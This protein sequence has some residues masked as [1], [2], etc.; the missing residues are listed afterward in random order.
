VIFSIKSRVSYPVES[1][2]KTYKFLVIFIICLLSLYCFFN[3]NRS[4]PR[5]LIL[6]P[7]ARPSKALQL[8]LREEL[9]NHTKDEKQISVEPVLN[10]TQ[11]IFYFGVTHD[12]TAGS[13]LDACLSTW[14]ARIQAHTGQK[15]I[16]YSNKADARVDHVVSTDDRDLYKDIT[17]RMLA[18]WRHV[19]ETYPDFEWYVRLWD[20]TIVFPETFEQ[21]IDGEA[22]NQL[23][24]IGRLAFEKT[25]E[26]IAPGRD[27]EITR[28]D[29]VFLDGGAGSLISQAALRVF[30]ENLDRCEVWMREELSQEIQC[31]FACEDVLLSAC[32]HRLLNITFK[33]GLGLYHTTPP[34]LP[35]GEH[36]LHRDVQGDPENTGYNSVTRSLHYASPEAMKRIDGI[37][38]ATKESQANQ[39]TCAFEG[40]QE[41]TAVSSVD[42]NRITLLSPSF[43]PLGA[44]RVV[45]DLI[46]FNDELDMLELRM[47]ELDPV[48]DFFVINEQPMTYTGR[49]KPMYYRLNSARFA[50]YHSKILLVNKTVPDS[51]TEP[52]ARGRASRVLGLMTVKAVAPANALVLYSDVDEVPTCW[53]IFVLKH[54]QAFPAA[55]FIHL[56]MQLY[57]YNLR[58]R[59]EN[60]FSNSQVFLVSLLDSYTPL[61]SL[62]L[63]GSTPHYTVNS[64]GWHCS[65]CMDVAGI[66]NKLRSFEHTEFSGPPFTDPEHILQCVKTG[67]DLF[68]RPHRYFLNA[69]SQIDGA[70]AP[71][72]LTIM[73]DRF[74]ER[75]RPLEIKA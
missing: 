27:S 74:V 20:D 73:P 64:A 40:P 1:M 66:S 26:L 21:L 56:S 12:S 59:A 5:A 63:D 13:R 32:K 30:V 7:G 17:W 4:V 75:F 53:T 22:P 11:Q 45:Y 23:V 10:Q 8:S 42:G 62:F 72:A 19:Y 50:T 43:Q 16:W 24:E 14:C 51:I 6:T 28:E 9:E 70:Q 31:S 35:L 25:G 68:L 55:T 67:S 29:R 58:W 33:R 46:T 61:E 41:I 36:Q 3:L 38:Y 65:Y 49:P 37:W 44:P 54:T 34:A 47:I 2:L 48:V 39:G 60:S 57:Y 18:I 71:Y 52:W 15:V 69:L